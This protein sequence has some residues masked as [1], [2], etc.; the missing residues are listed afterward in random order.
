M[1]DHLLQSHHWRARASWVRRNRD[2]ALA[3]LE[4][5]RLGARNNLPGAVLGTARWDISLGRERDIGGVKW[6]L[7]L[8]Y[9]GQ[10]KKI[11]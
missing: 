2:L 1:N 7:N 4:T 3:A 5:D 9:T 6:E 8:T 10:N 11:R